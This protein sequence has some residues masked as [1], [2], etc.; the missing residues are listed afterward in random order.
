MNKQLLALLALAVALPGSVSAKSD[1]AAYCTSLSQLYRHYL[2][3]STMEDVI[4]DVEGATAIAQCDTG[5]SAAAIG[6][7]EKK[8]RNVG[9]T[10]PR[11][12]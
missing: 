3:D 7:L 8:L 5:K 11:R 9:A 10:L 4:V 1:D 6:V 12:S 2:G